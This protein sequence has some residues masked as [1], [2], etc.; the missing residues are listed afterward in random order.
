MDFSQISIEEVFQVGCS[1]FEIALLNPEIQIAGIVVLLDMSGMTLLQQARLINPK[2]AW[3]LTNC[4][5]VLKYASS[6]A[7]YN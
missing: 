4:V 7:Y 2:F 6:C 1:I 5:Q 3:Q